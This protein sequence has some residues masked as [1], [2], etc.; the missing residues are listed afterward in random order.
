MYVNAISIFSTALELVD[1][2]KLFSKLSNLT[3]HTL[4]VYGLKQSAVVDVI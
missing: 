3:T 2:Q 1:H 4:T